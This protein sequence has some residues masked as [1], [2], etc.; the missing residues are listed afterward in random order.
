MNDS[1][2]YRKGMA[3]FSGYIHEKVVDSALFVDSAKQER[4]Q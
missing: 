1:E 3:F 4:A 2:G